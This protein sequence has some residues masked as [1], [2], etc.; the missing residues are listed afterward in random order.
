MTLLLW[1]SPF[2]SKLMLENHSWWKVTNLQKRIL[3]FYVSL[4]ERI[5]YFSFLLIQTGPWKCYF[6]CNY[7]L[8]HYPGFQPKDMVNLSM[9]SAESCNL[10]HGEKRPMFPHLG[11][12]IYWTVPKTM[13]SVSPCWVVKGGNGLGCWPQGVFV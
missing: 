10:F 6:I 13:K 12:F 2:W 11:L 7:F 3:H 9:I 1:I 5:P 8:S 4:L